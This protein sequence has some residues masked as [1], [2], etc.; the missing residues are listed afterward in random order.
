M[1][2][3]KKISSR[4]SSRGVCA[5]QR[6]D[7]IHPYN[8]LRSRGEEWA[9]REAS[10]KTSIPSLALDAVYQWKLDKEKSGPTTS[11]PHEDWLKHLENRDHVSCLYESF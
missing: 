5:D 2:L 11:L 4:T 3:K 10:K 1:V 7:E 9:L 6:S 8:A